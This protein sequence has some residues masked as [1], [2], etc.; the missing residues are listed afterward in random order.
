MDVIF[1]E[2]LGWIAL[3]IPPWG[4]HHRLGRNILGTR[5]TVIRV[6]VQRSTKKI[7]IKKKSEQTRNPMTI[8][9]ILL[10]AYTK[11]SHNS[12]P[13]SVTHHQQLIWRTHTHH[14]HYY[15]PHHNDHIN[16][17]PPPPSTPQTNCEEHR[18]NTTP[19]GTSTTTTTHHHHQ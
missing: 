11:N 10:L 3:R 4:L 19:P 5:V 18:R 13:D 17:P 7:D 8:P 12:N 6:S 16:N 15:Q 9:G 1:L 2:L 14:H